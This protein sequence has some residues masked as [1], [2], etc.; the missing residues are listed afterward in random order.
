M[1]PCAWH[2]KHCTIFVAFINIWIF[3]G[4][5]LP[6]HDF[7]AWF[8][9]LVGT[10]TR[11]YSWFVTLLLLLKMFSRFIPCSFSCSSIVFRL[12]S[13]KTGNYESCEYFF[14]SFVVVRMSFYLYFWNSFLMFCSVSKLDAFFWVLERSRFSLAFLLHSLGLFD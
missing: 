5:I 3:V 9:S 7:F 6:I 14:L 11:L 8:W 13:S 2:K 4:T 1:W 12:T 10:L